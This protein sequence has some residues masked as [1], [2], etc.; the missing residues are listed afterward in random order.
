MKKYIWMA[1][2]WLLW[3]PWLAAELPSQNIKKNQQIEKTGVLLYFPPE[4]KSVEAW[5][6]HEFK[7]G[8]LPLLPQT[9]EQKAQLQELLG[10]TITV[11]GTWFA[12]RSWQ[13]DPRLPEPVGEGQRGYGLLLEAIMPVNAS[14]EPN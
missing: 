7:V 5:H 11:R 1:C 12:G 6:G 14:F 4:V 2:C 9:P 8:D 10:Q 13:S 3:V